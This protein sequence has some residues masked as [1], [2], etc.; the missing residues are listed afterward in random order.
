MK[1]SVVVCLEAAFI[2]LDEKLEAL[3][4]K[5]KLEFTRRHN[6]EEGTIEAKEFEVECE[7]IMKVANDFIDAGYTNVQIQNEM[8][9]SIER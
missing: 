7:D 2:T 8:T 3:I 9:V 4:K 6:Y 5:Y 1:P